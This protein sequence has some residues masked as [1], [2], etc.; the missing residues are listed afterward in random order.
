VSKCS[1]PASVVGLPRS[2][3]G[4]YFFANGLPVCVRME[5]AKHPEEPLHSCSLSWDSAAGGLRGA[6]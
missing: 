4:V 6:E 1:N 3:N 5:R 2:V